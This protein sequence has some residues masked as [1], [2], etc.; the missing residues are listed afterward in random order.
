MNPLTIPVYEYDDA[1]RNY[2]G[3]CP[4]CKDFTRDCTEPDADGYDCP[5]CDGN[6]VVGA[7]QALMLGL[8]DLSCDGGV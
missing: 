2:L 3:F 5:Q 8:I 4:N 1:T 7:G 6:D